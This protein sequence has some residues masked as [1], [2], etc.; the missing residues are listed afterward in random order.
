M[1]ISRRLGHDQKIGIYFYGEITSTAALSSMVGSWS[2]VHDLSSSAF[3]AATTSSRL[4][5]WT[6]L[7][8][9]SADECSTA[10]RGEPAVV[11][12]TPLTFSSK[13]R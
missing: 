1:A 5:V 4:T 11:D 12:R 9:A 3:S 2:S 7:N 6:P 10:G 13:Y 8:D